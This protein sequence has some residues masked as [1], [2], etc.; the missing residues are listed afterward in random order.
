[1]M[2]DQ[3]APIEGNEYL[4]RRIH[5]SHF[6]KSLPIPIQPVAF[7]PTDSDEDGLSVFRERFTSAIEVARSGR[8][9]DSYYVVRLPVGS[10]LDLGLTVKPTPGDLP[11]HAVIVELNRQAYTSNKKQVKD[12]QLALARLASQTVVHRPEE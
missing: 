8:A 1:M 9:V 11:G 7:K 6:D 10:L 5:K 12:W 2:S 4:L 3:E